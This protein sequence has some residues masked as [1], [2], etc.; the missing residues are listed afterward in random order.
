MAFLTDG[1]GFK[2]WFSD[3][4]GICRFG[5]CTY[6]RFVFLNLRSPLG[7]FSIQARFQN[8]LVYSLVRLEG[9]NLYLNFSTLNGKKLGRCDSHG[10]TPTAAT[11]TRIREVLKTFVDKPLYLLQNRKWTV[12]ETDG[13]YTFTLLNDEDE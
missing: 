1:F 9:V 11:I 5:N 7:T 10:S 2:E 3:L 13:G 8:D 12:T 6:Y 4:F